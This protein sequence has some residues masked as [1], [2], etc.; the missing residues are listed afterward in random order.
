MKGYSWLLQPTLNAAKEVP[1]LNFDRFF[2]EFFT[3]WQKFGLMGLGSFLVE[4]AAGVIASIIGVVLMGTSAITLIRADY[5]GWDVDPSQMAGFIGGSISFV[6]IS[7][8]VAIVA[9]GLANAGLVGSIVAYRRGEEVSLGSFWTYAT[10]YFGKMIM[11]GVIL[12]GVMLVSMILMIIP[13]IGWLAL[14]IWGPTAMVVLAIYPSYLVVSEGYSVGQAVST[15]FRVL[16][17][18]FPEALMGGAILLG[19]GI[20]M[21]AISAIPLIGWLAIGIFGQV[22]IAFFFIERFEA[23]VRPKL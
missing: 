20:V 14:F 12:F 11:I 3:N 9:S 4:L 18:Q 10:Q 1:G 2:R 17:S 6:L 8:I 7:V 21:T 19:L 13:I 16:T 15:G 5:M 22:L 23:V